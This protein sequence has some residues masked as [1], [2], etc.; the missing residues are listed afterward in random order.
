MKLINVILFTIFV[1]G[2]NVNSSKEKINPINKPQGDFSNM[3]TGYAVNCETVVQELTI[4]NDSFSYK[5]FCLAEPHEIFDSADGFM[6]QIADSSF[7]LFNRDSTKE[8]KLRTINDSLII[9]T[10]K[11]GQKDEFFTDLNKKSNSN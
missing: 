2:C 10:I 6:R 11:P 4:R 7:F 1:Y 3:I 8:Y 9:L 5:R